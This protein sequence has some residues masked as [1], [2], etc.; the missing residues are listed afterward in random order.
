M[1]A[2]RRELIKLAMAT[3][4]YP[5]SSRILAATGDGA[6]GASILPLDR[7]GFCVDVAPLQGAERSITDYS[8]FHYCPLVDAMLLFGGG[9]AATP[10]DVVLRFPLSSLS[11][12]ADYAA[13]PKSTML[14]PTSGGV[15]DMKSR[16][17]DIQP[18]DPGWPKYLTAGKFWQVPGQSPAIRPVSRHSYTGFLWS[19]AIRKM[20]LAVG[21][22]G[23]CYGF[24]N[25]TTNGHMAEYDPLTRSWEDTGQDGG[26]SAAAWCEDPVSGMLLVHLESFFAAYD[27][28]TRQYVSRIA[29]NKKI[30]NFGYAGN[31]VYYPPGD[32]FYYF[33]RSIDPETGYS[34]V[35]E[36][37]LDRSR[38][39]PNYTKPQGDALYGFPMD[40]NWHP[41]APGSK[42]AGYAY[43][44]KNQLIVGSVMRNT[45]C[46]FKPSGNNSGTWYQQEA[47]GAA[48]TISYCQAY[49]STL[50]AHFTL[51]RTPHGVRTLAIRWDPAKAVK[52]AAPARAA[53]SPEDAATKSAVVGIASH[54][55]RDVDLK[56]HPDVIAYVDFKDVDTVNADLG[57][58]NVWRPG[59]PWYAIS[60]LP[61]GSKFCVGDPEF[62]TYRGLNFMRFSGTQ[63]LIAACL[64]AGKGVRHAFSRYVFM[65]EPDVPQFITD[66]VKLP[67]LAGEYEDTVI[68][69]P[70]AGKVTF[71]WRMNHTMSMAL[72]DYLYDGTTGSGYGNHH[73]YEV[74]LPIGEPIVLEQELDVDA[75]R[76][77]VWINGRFVGDRTVITDVDIE[78]LFLNVYHGG[79]GFAKAPVHYR[80]AGACIARSYIGPP[81]EIVA[82]VPA[83]PSTWPS[84]HSRPAPV[85]DVEGAPTSPYIR[86]NP[87]YG[88]RR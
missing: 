81:P 6:P 63:R 4:L 37:T 27:P 20:V 19:S 67:G 21:N 58:S 80:L 42:E 82:S 7:P 35:W 83:L 87:R 55:A 65:I 72:R 5:A 53:N 38:W 56:T 11:W 54:L 84:R 15:L 77:R 29:L 8:G 16:Y 76:G 60:K 43:D 2:D 39:Q 47:P 48:E 18:G 45:V 64:W 70:H 3:A 26:P 34:P 32:K 9:H 78:M 46:A 85:A 88:I 71:S 51:A 68:H 57:K 62:V 59:K 17:P 75:Q 73:P 28:R 41:P 66:G 30:P 23:T 10:E 61:D 24:P 44:A 1:R 36:Y 25:T 69:P 50:N 49:A 40:T 31:L 22:N 12:A 79:R 33:A 74:L 52:C 86:D 13:T 14:M